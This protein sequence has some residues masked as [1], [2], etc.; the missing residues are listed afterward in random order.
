MGHTKI[1][2]IALLCWLMAGWFGTGQALGPVQD[3][4]PRSIGSSCATEA[5]SFVWGG[6]FGPLMLLT[7]IEQG[8]IHRRPRLPRCW[9]SKDSG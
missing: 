9:N 3:T 5:F 6:I 8:I 1:P 4:Y 7:N 2:Y